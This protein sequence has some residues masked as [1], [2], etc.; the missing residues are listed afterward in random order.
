MPR[1]GNRNGIVSF[2]RAND[3]VLAI[4][5]NPNRVVF[6][7]R[8][9]ARGAV[10]QRVLMAQFVADIEK[11]LSQIIDLVRKEHAAAGFPRKLF[12]DLI[13]LV[14]FVLAADSLGGIL[15]VFGRNPIR[16]RA[17]RV[18]DHARALRH[19]DGLAAGAIAAVVIAVGNH[20][21]HAP[22]VRIRA[23]RQRRI[24]QQMIAGRVN[25][26]VQGR[27][28]AGALLQDRVAKFSG[29][30]REILDDLRA[31][32]ERHQERLVLARGARR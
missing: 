16:A 5:L 23:G 2:A 12:E 17:D 4:G 3:H 32:I 15:F 13:S 30:A 26:V 20:H 18:D 28:A 27:A 6:A 8:R 21:Q 22:H 9:A 25:R 31:V 19:F 10:G 11:R 1:C 24:I 14:F 7:V 29:V